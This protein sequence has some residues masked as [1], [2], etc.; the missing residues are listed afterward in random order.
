[1]TTDQALAIARRLMTEVDTAYLSTVDAEGYPQTRAMLNLHAPANFPA[2]EPVF[3]AAGAPWDLF[4]TTNTSS[5]KVAHILANPRASV[6]LTQATQFIGVLLVGTL[7]VV[8]DV[9]LKRAIWQPG[10]EMYYPGGVESDDYAV[11]RFTPAF[12]KAYHQFQV[13]QWS[14]PVA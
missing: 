14:F 11:L 1:M 7:S 3:A 2:L 13:A 6:C 5:A 4:F 9:D 12:G 10:W 8:S